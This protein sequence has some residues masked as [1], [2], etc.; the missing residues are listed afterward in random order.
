MAVIIMLPLVF[1]TE[2][3]RFALG[4]VRM[5]LPYKLAYTMTTALNMV[6]I[7]QVETSVIV[8]AQRLRAMHLLKK[9]N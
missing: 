8:D 9:E 1:T 2:G 7:L 5:G 6:P 4:L 3:S